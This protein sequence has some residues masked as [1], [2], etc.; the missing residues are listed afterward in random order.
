[1][2]EISKASEKKRRRWSVFFVIIPVSILK[3]NKTVN[4]IQGLF[5]TEIKGGCQ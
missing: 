3:C 2:E 1:M 4:E 5:E